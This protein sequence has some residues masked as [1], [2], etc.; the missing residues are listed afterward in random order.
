MFAQAGIH[1]IEQLRELGTVRA[2]VQVKRAG[3]CS[4]LNLWWAMEAALSGRH[5]QEIAKNDRLTLLLQL[6]DVEIEPKR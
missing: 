4:S 3:A 5:W 1:T 6:E 2:Y